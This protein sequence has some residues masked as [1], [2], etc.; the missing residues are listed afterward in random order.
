VNTTYWFGQRAS[1]N[2]F[3]ARIPAAS[4][5][6][7]SDQLAARGVAKRKSPIRRSARCSMVV[8][9]CDA[10]SADPRALIGRLGVRWSMRD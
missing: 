1:K 6:L 3:D 4:T 5:V 8:G 10:G 9:Y 7:L 2:L